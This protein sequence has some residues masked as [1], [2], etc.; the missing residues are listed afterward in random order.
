M[1]TR[2]DAMITFDEYRLADNEQPYFSTRLEMQRWQDAIEML[3]TDDI[4][5]FQATLVSFRVDTIDEYYE[6]TNWAKRDGVKRVVNML[7][8]TDQEK[9]TQF[10]L[11]WA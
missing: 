10:K 5:L 7:M 6:L 9:L 1:D 8:F 4:D 3:T 11:R 2:S